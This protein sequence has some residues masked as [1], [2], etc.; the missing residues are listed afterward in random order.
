MDQCCTQQEVGAR[1][2]EFLSAL[3]SGGEALDR[4]WDFV[5]FPATSRACRL[6]GEI[7]ES[8]KVSLKTGDLVS[9]SEAPII[10]II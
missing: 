1:K 3:A 2:Q 7:Y 10:C 8:A 5:G 4:R 9:R 6:S